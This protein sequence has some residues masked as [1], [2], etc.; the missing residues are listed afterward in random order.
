MVVI[1]VVWEPSVV[2]RPARGLTVRDA[3]ADQGPYAHGTP[4]GRLVIGDD[5]GSPSDLGTRVWSW[6]TEEFVPIAGPDA[7]EVA[8][9]SLMR[10]RPDLTRNQFAGHWRERHAPLARRRHVGLADYHQYVVFETLTS[11][12]PE[13]DGVA[14]LGFRTRAD[15]EERF[16][17]S[18]EGRN[19]IMEDVGRFMDRPGPETTLVGP[20]GP[21]EA[22]G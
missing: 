22:A 18:D 16:F 8:M 6:R 5:A 2:W 9:V 17:D 20:P 14:L 12:T 21:V 3:V 13:I 1:S 19:E 7:C 15:F 4:F 10:R 11:A